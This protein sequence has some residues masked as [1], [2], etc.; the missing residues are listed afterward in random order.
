MNATQIL[1]TIWNNDMNVNSSNIRQI[2]QESIQS[3]PSLSAL[4]VVGADIFGML[5]VN[6]P[7]NVYDVL[8]IKRCLPITK[9]PTS[10][11]K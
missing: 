9:R 10:S 7:K 11:W 2:L 6:L 3:R 4:R 8:S 5:F 1:I